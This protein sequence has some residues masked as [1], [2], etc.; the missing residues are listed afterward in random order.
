MG[1]QALAAAAGLWIIGVMTSRV[2]L[3]SALILPR[4]S[5]SVGL[6]FTAIIAVAG[7]V[8]AAAAWILLMPLRR[9]KAMRDWSIALLLIVFLITDLY[10]LS[11]TGLF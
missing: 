4:L 8:A 2:G 11:W 5:I 1:W 10:L 6:R 9:P 3:G 7:I